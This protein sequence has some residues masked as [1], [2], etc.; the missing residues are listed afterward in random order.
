MTLSIAARSPS[1]ESWGVAVVSGSLAVGAVV[2]AARAGVGAVATQGRANVAH[3]SRALELM[4]MEASADVTLALLL[5]TDQ[6]RKRRQ[7]GLVDAAGGAVTH[8]G[9]QCPPWAGGRAG[10]GVAVQGDALDGPE[11]VDAITQTWG[12]SQGTLSRRLL[13]AL[14]AGAAGG[15]A[16][17]LRSSALYVV[18]D[19]AG[20]GG[21]DDVE[22]DLRVDDHDD[23]CAELERLL[24]LHELQSI[25]TESDSPASQDGQQESAS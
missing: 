1:G 10:A 18:R 11:V 17:G 7:V 22:V 16:G 20:L 9:S 19:R 2:P 25:R 6:G 23:P 12:S 14:R 15:S 4:S 24:A 3:K 21:R 5:E 13:T 8:T